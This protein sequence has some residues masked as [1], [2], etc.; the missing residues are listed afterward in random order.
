MGKKGKMGKMG[1]MGGNGEYAEDVTL[2]VAKALAATKGCNHKHLREQKYI[3]P[4]A[5]SFAHWPGKGARAA[6]GVTSPH[7]KHS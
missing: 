2:A 1:E 4:S 6:K 7:P 3:D 5:G